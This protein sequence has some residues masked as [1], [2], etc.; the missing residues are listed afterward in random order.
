M[1]RKIWSLSNGMLVVLALTAGAL[2][3]CGPE[4]LVVGLEPT[5]TPTPLPTP[6]V[7][8]YTNDE[9]GFTFRYPETWTLSKDSHLVQLKQGTLVLSIAHGWAANP[10]FNPM[11]GRTG[12]PAGD[13]IYGDKIVF[14]ERPVPARILEF[15]RKDKMVLYGE[16][17]LIEVD[18]LAFSI[19]LEDQGTDYADLDIPKDTQADAVEILESFERIEAT[20]RPP[21]PTATPA[22][23]TEKDVLT[24]VNED[25]GLAF[26]YPS[27]WELE[28]FPP[29]QE[30]PRGEA[31]ATV[32]LTK[33][34]LRLGIQF[35][36]EGEN[37]VL[38]PSGRPAGE[39][40][41]R[42]TVTV[43]GH[44]I[45][46]HVLVFVGKDKSVFL[47]DR[48]EGVELYSQLDGG[49]GV[50]MPYED[51]EIP[52]SAQAAME[53]IL[54]SLTFT[55]DGP[56]SPDQD[57]LTYENAEYGF[58]FQHPAGWAMEEVEGGMADLGGETAKL[59]DS[60]VLSRGELA[61][62]LQ[63]Q[64]KATP[65]WEDSRL[66][67][68]LFFGDAVLGEKVTVMG[69]ETQKR[70]WTYDDGIKA[71]FV[72]AVPDTADLAFNIWLSNNSQMSV[73]DPEAPAVSESAMAALD[74][75]LSSLA[76]TP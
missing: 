16:T 5:P 49:Y 76:A 27:D 53:A 48:V 24:Y 14:L 39:I 52:Q 4:T 66:P 25:Y 59:S 33:D 56:A 30:A 55:D 3:A 12:M 63:V 54:S 22:P 44:D 18:D 47:A 20:G 46:K 38:G 67:A 23:S 17:A 60:V 8:S 45:P 37:W 51:I 43:L 64:H 36:R 7:R 21:A 40:D 71:V 32:H 13:F 35:R 26:L 70:I 74:Q 68:D 6:V 29:G 50:Q 15:E 41:K 28:A 58:T 62:V 31:A 34:T 42:G 10:G 73:Q 11:G 2:T 65:F 72:Q 61:I 19:W 75:V 1:Y 69:V 9:Y 57:T